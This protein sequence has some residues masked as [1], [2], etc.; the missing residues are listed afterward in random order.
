[1][2]HSTNYL[3]HLLVLRASGTKLTI[4]ILFAVYTQYLLLIS[5]HEVDPSMQ[6]LNATTAAKAAL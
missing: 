5:F 6:E 1:M 3:K 4:T 2:V